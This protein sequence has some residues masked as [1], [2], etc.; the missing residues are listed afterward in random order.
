MSV[1]LVSI[2]PCLGFN[3]C[4]G[5]FFVIKDL[6]KRPAPESCPS[7]LHSVKCTVF[8]HLPRRS[9]HKWQLM[10]VTYFKHLPQAS[11]H[12]SLPAFKEQHQFH[13]C[14]TVWTNKPS[15]PWLWVV[16]FQGQSAEPDPSP[17]TGEETLPRPHMFNPGSLL[18]RR[19]PLHIHMLWYLVGTFFSVQTHG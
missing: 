1:I 9:A 11:Y 6:K 3:L 19:H 8:T 12:H 4:S 2:L 10:T 7:N 18:Q 13:H 15:H 16:C 17:E 14:S 5:L